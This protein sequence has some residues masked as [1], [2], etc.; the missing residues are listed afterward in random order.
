MSKKTR[1]E[2]H[3]E[4]ADESWL[5][6]YSDLMTL[7]VALFLVMYAMSATDAK[8]FEE[9][10][11]AFSSALNGGSGVMEYRSDAP[12]STQ[13]DQG[14]ADKMNN[15]VAPNTGTAD[16]AKLRKKEQEELE[17]LKK[18]FDQYIKNNG[19]TDLLS[20][21]LNQS[22]LTITISDN[23]LFS[24]GQ[25]VVKDESRQLAKSISTMLQQ[26]PNYEVLVEGHTDNIPISNSEYPSN[27]DL[28]VARALQFMKI[29]L[30]NPY[31]DPVKFSPIGYGEYHPIADNDTAAG[32][33][34]N[35]RVEVSILRK[36]QDVTQT[37]P[38]TPSN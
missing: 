22:Q 17:K 23:A 10:A 29:L 24:S 32:R 8:K 34:K 7:L 16:I 30:L 21:K 33:A 35:R 36:Y 19:L 31:L 14:K 27:W 2:E 11:Q 5:L 28:S 20:T 6:P 15:V 25:A 12:T 4:H 9:M 37:T 13:L 3:E 18:Q 38:V 1:H 26:F